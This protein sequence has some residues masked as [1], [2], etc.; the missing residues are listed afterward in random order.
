MPRSRSF[1]VRWG[2]RTRHGRGGTSGRDS[3]THGAL[4]HRSACL[5]TAH[6]PVNG[7]R[8]VREAAEQRTDGAGHAHAVHAH[9]S[10][11][12]L[13]AA[14]LAE[15]QGA[16]GMRANRS[17]PLGHEST[18]GFCHFTR[19]DTARVVTKPD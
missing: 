9:R 12:H 4:Q 7:V 5:L 14:G 10:A 18:N 15:E 3:W 13:V 2:T 17:Q 1:G 8:E 16:D 11:P 6:R 19:T